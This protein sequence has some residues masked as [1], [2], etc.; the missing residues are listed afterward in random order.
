MFIPFYII[1]NQDKASMGFSWDK[2]V[3]FVRI[4]IAPVSSNVWS[5]MLVWRIWSLSRFFSS[6]MFRSTFFT[7]LLFCEQ[8]YRWVNHK[9]G[10]SASDGNEEWGRGKKSCFRIFSDQKLK[11]NSSIVIVFTLL[12]SFDTQLNSYVD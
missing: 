6:D 2:I 12:S 8:F 10:N 7:F 11:K 9:L 5:G 4:L 1:T 3:V